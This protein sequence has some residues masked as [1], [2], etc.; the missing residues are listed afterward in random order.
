V[1]VKRQMEDKAL[2]H[3]KAKRLAPMWSSAAG[4]ADSGPR[5]AMPIVA[6]GI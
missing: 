4:V 5:S 3:A 2:A 1:T 6:H